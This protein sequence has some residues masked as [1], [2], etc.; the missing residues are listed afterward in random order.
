MQGQK[1][2]SL[3]YNRLCILC[4]TYLLNNSQMIRSTIHFS[5]PLICDDWSHFHFIVPVMPDKAAFVSAVLLCVQHFRG[6]SK[7]STQW[8][9]M[10]LHFHSDQRKKTNKRA[11]NMLLFHVDVNRKRL[12]IRFQLYSMIQHRHSVLRDNTFIHDAVSDVKLCMM[13]WIKK[14]IIGTL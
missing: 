1:T 9:T 14:P 5:K 2:L 3:S 12:G 8:Q 13:K 4:L 10:N 7:S 11:G 6:S